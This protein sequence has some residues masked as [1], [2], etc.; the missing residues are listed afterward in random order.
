MEPVREQLLL[1]AADAD[2]FLTNANWKHALCLHLW[3]IPINTFDTFI[4]KCDNLLFK[5]SVV[6][7]L[8]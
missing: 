4:A 7:S 2:S 3:Q 6:I 8:L 5:E 1:S